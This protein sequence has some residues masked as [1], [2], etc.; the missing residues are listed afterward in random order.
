MKKIINSTVSA[1]LALIFTVCLVAC[2]NTVDK[3][4]LW[5]NA[6]YLK[7][8]EFGKGE[9]TV[10][11]EVAVEEQVVT[12]TINTDKDTVGDALIEHNL[13]EGEEGAY[14]LYIKKVNG[15]TADFDVDQSYWAF[16][17]NGEYAMTGVDMTEINEGDIYRIEYAK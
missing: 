14:G 11:V 9:K 2:G 7:D 1:V 12:F 16:Y 10:V 8:K 6:T 3:S 15:I 4:G 5:E 13:I 17:V